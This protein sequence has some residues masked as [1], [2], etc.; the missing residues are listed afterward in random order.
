[1]SKTGI[2]KAWLALLIILS[3]GISGNTARRQADEFPQIVPYMLPGPVM[4]VDDGQDPVMN[5]LFRTTTARRQTNLGGLWDFKVD[6]SDRGESKGFTSTFP[7]PDTQVWLPGSWN[8]IARYYQYLGAAWFRRRFEVSDEAPLRICFSGVFYHARV[9]LDGV[10]LGEHEGG[11]SP[12]SFVVKRVLP[13]N[14]E[15]TARVDNRLSDET[16]P[17]RGIDWFPYGGIHRPIYLE[18]VAPTYI[19]RFH[20]TI[21]AVDARRATL[22]VHVFL[23]NL[24]MTGENRSVEFSVDGHTLYSGT[25]MVAPGESIAE[26]R[27]TVDN[28]R[29]WSP[30]EPY[31]Y[32]ARV[33][34]NGGEDDQFSRFGIRSFTAEGNQIL[35]NGRRFKLKGANRHEDHPDWGPSLPPQ[36]LRQDIEILK[37]MGANAVR[38]HYPFSELF[39]DYCD[40]SGI[41]VLSE[42]PSWQYDAR[43]LASHS[44]Q[45]K[46]KRQYL[47]M[48]RRDMN[49]PCIL[50][51]SLGNEW[52]DFDRSYEQIKALVD[53]AR[54]VDSSHFITFVTGGAKIG[55]PSELLDIICTNWAQYQWYEPFTYLDEAE[56]AKSIAKLE[57]IRKRFPNKP[58]ILT[59]FGGAESQ[60]GWHSWGNVKWSEEYQARNVSDSGNYSLEQDWIS[61]G[62]VWQF[63]DTRSDPS[64]MLGPRLRGW[65]AKGVLDAYRQPKMAF[66]RLQD[67]YHHFDQRR[68]P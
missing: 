12:F 28:P 65:N 41:V 30:E 5:R 24:G 6:P 57:E 32:S 23:R 46:V 64:R 54:S 21:E 11:Y 67:L 62:C 14:H 3:A 66:Y 2:S 52:P 35:L 45:E 13:G 17:K 34:L 68:N 56:G 26:F 40:Q 50:S 38:G 39:L 9:W 7:H 36:M 61:G 42:I 29:L 53:Y 18:S 19:D 51:W 63:C 44:I 15:L 10:C 49:R 25:H 33:V 60:A 59:E 27:V 16:L 48:V 55:R 31:L 1:M 47:E 4:S 43:Q 8:T 20:V 37:R 22:L 58:V